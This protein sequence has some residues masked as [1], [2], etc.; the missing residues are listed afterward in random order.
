LTKSIFLV[1]LANLVCKRR[2]E[3]MAQ[4]D[5]PEPKNV[6]EWALDLLIVIAAVKISS[7]FLIAPGVTVGDQPLAVA[8][9]AGIG[10]LS[11]KL[12][13]RWVAFK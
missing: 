8:A 2:K 10:A 12:A 3:N 1:R 4:V 9:V 7:L 5:L 6:G 11:Y 13:R